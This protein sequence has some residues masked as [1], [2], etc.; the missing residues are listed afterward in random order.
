MEL[1]KAKGGKK[2]LIVEGILSTGH[3]QPWEHRII[4][5]APRRRWKTLGTQ[6]NQTGAP[7]ARDDL[8]RSMAAWSAPVTRED[9]RRL[10]RPAGEERPGTG[11]GDR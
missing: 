7:P 2:Y 4:R 3:M 1:I 11:D 9:G 5:R 10:L 8:R 6:N